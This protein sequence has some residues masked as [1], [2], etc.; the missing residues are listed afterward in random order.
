[1]KGTAYEEGIDDLTKITRLLEEVEELNSAI[2]LL[3]EQKE[4]LEDNLGLYH[5]NDVKKGEGSFEKYQNT[6]LD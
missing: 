1:M 6:F 5:F 3:K 4:Q 2:S